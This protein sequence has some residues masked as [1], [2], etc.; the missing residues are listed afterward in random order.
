M[1]SPGP[2]LRKVEIP[3]WEAADGVS[4]A[5][6]LRD[7]CNEMLADASAH[8]SRQMGI[9]VQITKKKMQLVM[10]EQP[11]S[12]DPFEVDDQEDIENLPIDVSQDAELVVLWAQQFPRYLRY[13]NSQPPRSYCPSKFRF[14]RRLYFRMEKTAK[15]ILL[16]HEAKEAARVVGY[17]DLDFTDNFSF[18]EFVE[19]PDDYRTEVFEMAVAS[20]LDLEE[21]DRQEAA[22]YEQQVEYSSASSDEDG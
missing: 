13:I 7:W 12:L 9:R 19:D 8:F 11:P 3:I 15:K 6:Y 20:T 21:M 1:A 22:E 2:R 17:F 10:A 14:F 4:K 16:Y 5:R 18:A